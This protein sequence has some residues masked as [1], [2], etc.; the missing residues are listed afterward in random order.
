MEQQE[1]ENKNILELVEG[2]TQK[3]NIAVPLATVIAGALIAFAVYQRPPTDA[4]N[5][6]S[7]AA[8]VVGNTTITLKPIGLDDHI[9][10]NPDAPVKLVE[11]SDMECPFCK[12]FHPTMKQVMDEYGKKG[13]VAWV[14]RHLPLESI[15]TKALKEAEAT[16]CANRLGGNDKF[17]AYLDRIFEITPSNDGLDLTLLPQIAQDIGLNRSE[18]EAC[19]ASGEFTQKIK[20]SI[21]EATRAGAQGTPYT[22]VVT[23]KGTKIPI[24][25]ALPYSSVKQTIDQALAEK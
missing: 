7:N 4:S 17:W 5:K 22:L 19:L 3:N 1:K 23:E 12:R 18:F 8:A 21:T 14:Y 16:E 20:D 25:G 11:Y 15:H 2:K 10:G 6:N 9:L 13:Q 24:S